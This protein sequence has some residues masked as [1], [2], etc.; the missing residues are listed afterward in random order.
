MLPE[1]EEF[2]MN[3]LIPAMSKG[4]SL[5]DDQKKIQGHLLQF[6]TE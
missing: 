3:E 5:G 2:T 4:S 1:V 6:A